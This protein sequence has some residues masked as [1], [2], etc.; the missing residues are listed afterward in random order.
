MDKAGQEYLSA[1]HILINAILPHTL[2][3]L[4]EHLVPAR[5]GSVSLASGALGRQRT[6]N[7]RLLQQWN[8]PISEGA[9]NA[10]AGASGAYRKSFKLATK[11]EGEKTDITRDEPRGMMIKLG[12]RQK[13]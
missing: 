2:W 6:S 12:L 9:M 7:E 10:S 11:G 5:L 4:C 8:P 3:G 1:Y 13:T